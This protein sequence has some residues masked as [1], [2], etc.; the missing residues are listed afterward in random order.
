MGRKERDSFAIQP[1]SQEFSR[2]LSFE[3]GFRLEGNASVF[4]FLPCAC[5]EISRNDFIFFFFFFLFQFANLIIRRNRCS[6]G[7][8]SRN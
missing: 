7:R 4:T 3:R 6:N 8:A 5:H 2:G 1:F